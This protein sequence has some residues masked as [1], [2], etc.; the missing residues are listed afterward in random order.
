MKK[1]YYSWN[2]NLFPR[3]NK[4]REPIKITQIFIYYPINTKDIFFLQEFDESI[5]F[6]ID[7]KRMMK[8]TIYIAT[9][10]NELV[11]DVEK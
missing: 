1:D 4:T 5:D 3:K 2:C 9:N 7:F 8:D 10:F 11:E 6:R